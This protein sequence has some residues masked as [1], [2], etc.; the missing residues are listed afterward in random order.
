MKKC[1]C[2]KETKPFSEFNKD[3][4]HSTKYTCYCK[5]CRRNLLDKK[6]KS[7]YDLNK[8]YGLTEEDYLEKLTKQNFQCAICKTDQ[9]KKKNWRRFAVDHCHTTGKIRGLLCHKCNAG[10]GHFDDDTGLL[11]SA[12]EYL[13]NTHE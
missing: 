6:K 8:R 13:E 3:K 4:Q 12:I 1:G 2:C 5:E 9:Y 7:A 10:L 11:N